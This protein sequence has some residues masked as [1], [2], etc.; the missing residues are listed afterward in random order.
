MKIK[1]ND[2]IHELSY[3]KNDQDLLPLIAYTYP[4]IDGVTTMTQ[5]KF[6]KWTEFVN[7]S[8]KIDNLIKSVSIIDYPKYVQAVFDRNPIDQF[9]TKDV[10]LKW[11]LNN[12]SN[13]IH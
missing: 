1:V 5:Q 7:K 13:M 9:E 10:Q 6:D 3:I 12:T 11:L 4:C 2:I 8:Y